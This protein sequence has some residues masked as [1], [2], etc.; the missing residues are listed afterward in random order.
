MK[1]KVGNWKWFV[2]FALVVL[3]SAVTIMA[4]TAE[5]PRTQ[6]AVVSRGNLLE[7]AYSVGTVKA[8][9]VFNLKVGVATRL[10]E[11]HVRIG[12]AVKKG[13]RLIA[14][15]GFPT[16]RAPFD[17][18]ISNVS[19]EEGEVVQ[20]Q[21]VVLTLT[22]LESLF[23]ELSLDERVISSIRAGQKARISFEGQRS[24]MKIGKVRAVYSNA[25][26]FLAL[27]DFESAGMS[28]LPGMTSDVA[29]EIQEHK[30]ELLVPLG[31]IGEGNQ[32]TIADAKEPRKIRVAVGASDGEFAVVQSD[33]LKEGDSLVIPKVRSAGRPPGGP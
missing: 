32:V 3:A 12:D 20:P 24:A 18:V 30:N 19:Y 27:V 8:D 14:L 17:G 9:K 31:A 6:H 1:K 25:G 7:A 26:Q 11:R 2:G 28:L 4:R 22:N 29:V 23:L 16:Y 21:T 33:D 15:E 5:S 10:A 13:D